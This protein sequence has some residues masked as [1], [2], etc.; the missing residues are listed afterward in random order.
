MQSQASDA[1]RAASG[2]LCAVPCAA[3]A[4]L[5][6]FEEVFANDSRDGNFAFEFRIAHNNCAT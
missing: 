1:V 3:V 6:V 5:M 4:V 2:S